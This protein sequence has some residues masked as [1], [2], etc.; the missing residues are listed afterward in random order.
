M[1]MKFAVI[2]VVYSCSSLI[3]INCGAQRGEFIIVLLF[4]RNH[5]KITLKFMMVVY[6]LL[7]LLWIISSSSYVLLQHYCQYLLYNIATSVSPRLSALLC[8]FS[9]ILDRDGLTHT[10]YCRDKRQYSL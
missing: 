7:W 5:S 2:L 6:G 10:I 8:P 4:I 9:S 3:F 1:I